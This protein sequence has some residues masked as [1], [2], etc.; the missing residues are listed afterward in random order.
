MIL[1]KLLDADGTAQRKAR[2]IK[3][4]VYRCKVIL[5]LVVYSTLLNFNKRDQTISGTW[6]VT[7][8]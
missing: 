7:I 8:N 3:R 4:R 2:R 1:L 5:R 6:T